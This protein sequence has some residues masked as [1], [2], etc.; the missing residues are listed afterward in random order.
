LFH[1]H[2]PLSLLLA[3]R[4][5]IF[6]RKGLLD[7]LL[8]VVLPVGLPVIPP[9]QVVLFVG[10]TAIALVVARAPMLMRAV[11]LPET[12]SVVERLLLFLF[13]LLLFL[14]LLLPLLLL[15][16]LSTGIYEVGPL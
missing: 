1:I 12:L 16:L 6:R 2:S 11:E 3:I 9:T 14:P 7:S 5:L 15:L 8:V 10:L 4:S 13:L